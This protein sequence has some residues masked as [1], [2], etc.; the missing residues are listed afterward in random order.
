TLRARVAELEAAQVSAAEHRCTECGDPMSVWCTG[1]AK[2]R[3]VDE[4]DA[5]CPQAEAGGVAPTQTP[6]KDKAEPPVPRT[7]RS[8]WEDIATA[9]NAAVAAGMPIGVD[10][11]GTLTDR[12]AWSV[13]WDR[14]AERWTVA[15]Y[16]DEPAETVATPPDFYQPGRTYSDSEY[17]WKFRCDTVVTH[18]EDGERTAL[19][20]RFFDGRWE[21][22]AYGED[23]WEVGQAVG[24][25]DVTEGGAS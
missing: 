5:G 22:Y 24:Y 16:E 13:V 8:Y 17:G 1:C 3:C 21:P 19:G 10:L 12:T 2:C 4:H 20:W 18:P 15:G 25:S 9:L 11:D 23:D 7:E 14:A 6:R